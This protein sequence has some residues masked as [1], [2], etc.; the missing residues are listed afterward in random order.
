MVKFIKIISFECETQRLIAVLTLFAG[1]HAFSTTTLVSS[2]PAKETIYSTVHP[3]WGMHCWYLSTEG[4]GGVHGNLPCR[5]WG[6]GTLCSG[7]RAFDFL[8]SWIAG[9]TS[10]CSCTSSLHKVTHNGEMTVNFLHSAL[11]V[12][13]Q[14]SMDY[15][16]IDKALSR[17]Q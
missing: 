1:F 5:Q 8:W 2:P 11:F 17:I 13:W 12:S 16:A 6:Q 10:H 9:E 14:I 3:K 4:Q 15:E 7:S